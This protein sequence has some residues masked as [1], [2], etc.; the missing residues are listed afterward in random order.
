MIRSKLALPL[1]STFN[2]G[3][4]ACPSTLVYVPLSDLLLIV[5]LRC[6]IP[7]SQVPSCELLLQVRPRG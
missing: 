4:E 6:D 5:E 3:E 7:R 1:C 2:R